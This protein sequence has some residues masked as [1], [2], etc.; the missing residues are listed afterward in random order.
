[1]QFPLWQMNFVFFYPFA[2]LKPAAL[3]L[4]KEA[5]FEEIKIISR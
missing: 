4:K 3:L 5:T 1:M 2:I